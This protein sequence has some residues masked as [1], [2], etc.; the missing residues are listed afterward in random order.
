ML[1]VPY[2]PFTLHHCNLPH[3]PANSPK[4]VGVKALLSILLLHHQEMTD[5]LILWHLQFQQNHLHW[6]GHIQQLNSKSRS[7]S[8]L[9]CKSLRAGYPHTYHGFCGQSTSVDYLKPVDLSWLA[10]FFNL[11]FALSSTIR[12][13]NLSR[14][15]KIYNADF[16]SV[17]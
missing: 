4:V 13:C 17:P 9:V 1:I 5:M 10:S 11:I 12:K 6:T 15:H 8:E 3:C 2:N 14:R 7:W 16:Q